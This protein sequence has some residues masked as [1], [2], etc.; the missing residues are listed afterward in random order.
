MKRTI[1]KRSRKDWR[2]RKLMQPAPRDDVPWI[3]DPPSEPSRYE[4]H[5]HWPAYMKRALPLPDFG[6]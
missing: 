5:A 4:P 6:T 1:A 3:E 2:K